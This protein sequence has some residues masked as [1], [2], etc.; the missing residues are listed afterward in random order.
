VKVGDYEIIFKTISG[1]EKG[2]KVN[3]FSKFSKF[4]EIKQID[5]IDFKISSLELALLQSALV[6]DNEE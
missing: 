2:K 1:T 6:I 4:I 3:L 5:D